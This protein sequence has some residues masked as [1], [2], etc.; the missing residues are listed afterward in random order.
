VPVTS[1]ALP[2]HSGASLCFGVVAEEVPR[3][4][5][6]FR[7]RGHARVGATFVVGG[8]GVPFLPRG[9]PRAP[10]APLAPP[11]RA[12]TTRCVPGAGGG[13]RGPDGSSRGPGSVRDGAT[14]VVG[15]G[16]VPFLP[17]GASWAP[18]A[19]LAPGGRAVA[20]QR[21]R[22]EGEGVFHPAEGSRGPERVRG[23][24]ISIAA[25]DVAHFRP[26]GASRCPEAT[27]ALPGLRS[28]RGG[29][30]RW[31]RG[32][33]YFS[34][35][36]PAV[37]GAVAAIASFIVFNVI[38]NEVLVVSTEQNRRLVIFWGRSM[39]APKI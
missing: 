15:G 33:W 36:P 21:V 29:S 10:W 22:D 2:F 1:P 23:G 20:S 24:A 4:S 11:G 26:R 37:W 19:P 31:W 18:G 30:S 6:G 28:S 3:S 39:V 25:G 7:R 27:L 12:G 17:R 5:E 34:L 14:P 35:G 9:S 16:G 13:S 38:E 32:P 8:G